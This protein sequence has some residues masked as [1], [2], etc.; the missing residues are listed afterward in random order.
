MLKLIKNREKYIIFL[1]EKL[2]NKGGCIYTLYKGRKYLECLKP[3]L[4]IGEYNAL[5]TALSH[6]E[7][8]E[9]AEELYMEIKKLKDK[10][11]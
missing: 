7:L 9:G 5:S 1:L 2:R 6:F 4:L 3:Y 11:E 10:Y 8:G